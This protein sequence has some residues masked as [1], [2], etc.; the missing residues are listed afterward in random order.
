MT[1]GWRQLAAEVRACTHCVAQL[2]QAPKPILQFDPAARIL[3]AGQAPGRRAHDAGIPFNDAS[4]DRLRAWLGIDRATFY[5]A[6][7]VAVVPMGFCFPGTA[8]GGDLPPLPACAELWRERLL[9]QLVN[10]QLTLVIGRYALAWH[11]PE[12]TDVTTAVA[13]WRAHWP[14]VLPLPHPSPRNQAWFKRNPWFE[15]DV[16][17]AL[18]ER[19]Q[20]VL[21]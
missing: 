19:V 21:D 6:S 13:G 12:T 8:R 10:V 2:P 17:S 15:S 16:L 7:R 11:L 20:R 3:I 9:K 14:A 18:R 4:G 5:D 1:Q